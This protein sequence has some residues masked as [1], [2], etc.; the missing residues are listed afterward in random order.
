MNGTQSTVAS[1][2]M[3]SFEPFESSCFQ[4]WT[5]EMS[6]QLADAASNASANK[7]SH[8]DKIRSIKPA[9]FDRVAGRYGQ[10]EFREI[11]RIITDD[12]IERKMPSLSKLL[13]VSKIDHKEYHCQEL[14][15]SSKSKLE[16]K[17]FNAL[18]SHLVTV[19]F[20]GIHL[21]VCPSKT[22]KKGFQKRKGLTTH[23]T[24]T[25]KEND[26]LV[27]VPSPTK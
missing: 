27:P 3:A 21:F 17:N 4:S 22:C 19:H 25:H 20:D 2:G 1:S 12:N 13:N 6:P 7:K 9:K 16:F 26:D 5:T 14:H 18:V 24:R 10:Q 11:V 8:V 15:D 23:K